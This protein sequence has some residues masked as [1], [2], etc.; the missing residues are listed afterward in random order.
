MYTSDREVA[1]IQYPLYLTRV[2]YRLF[3]HPDQRYD[4]RVFRVVAEKK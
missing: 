4:A 1:T 2:G 3:D